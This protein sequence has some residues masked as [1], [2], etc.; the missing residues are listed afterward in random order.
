MKLHEATEEPRWTNTGPKHA[1]P[2]HKRGIS[3]PN[4]RGSPSGSYANTEAQEQLAQWPLGGTDLFPQEMAADT[5]ERVNS[6]YTEIPF[7]ISRC[8]IK[9]REK[10]S[11]EAAKVSF[12]S[13]KGPHHTQKNERW[14]T[15]ISEDSS[16][17][18]RQGPPS[19][20]SSAGAPRVCCGGSQQEG[21]E[22]KAPPPRAA[23]PP[24]PT[25]ERWPTCSSYRS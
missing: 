19:G 12:P 24:T 14:H 13:R 11:L 17:T 6:H 22:G 23:T 9:Q 16:P 10:W 5:R 8:Q 15:V 20:T 7:S 25:S 2:R 21:S 18:A 4:A 1:F 3:K